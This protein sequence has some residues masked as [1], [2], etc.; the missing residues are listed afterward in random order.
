MESRKII[1]YFEDIPIASL[2]EKGNQYLYEINY[3]NLK[4]AIMTGCPTFI[5]GS[6]EGLYDDLPT[7][8]KELETTPGR[9]DIY[10]KLGIV[11]GDS[12]FDKLYKKAM[13]SELFLKDCF[14]ISVE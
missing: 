12:R 5:V 7:V 14:W 1:L 4:K 11:Q 3:D 2:K 8:F 9:V 6:K 13:K 10:Q